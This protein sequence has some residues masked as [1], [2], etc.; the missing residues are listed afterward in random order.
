MH[1]DL[2]IIFLQLFLLSMFE[3]LMFAA[4]STA[5][6]SGVKHKG[7]TL[8]IFQ[9][10]FSGKRELSCKNNQTTQCANSIPV[11]IKLK[12]YLAG[13]SEKLL[14]FIISHSILMKY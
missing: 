1:A 8:V 13:E 9:K 7:K 6:R 14:S 2:L 5:Q 3:M 10:I 12:N 4:R 11:K